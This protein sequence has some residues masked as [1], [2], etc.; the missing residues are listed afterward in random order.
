MNPVNSTTS[1]WKQRLW[2]LLAIIMT[3]LVMLIVGA[4]LLPRPGDVLEV[5]QWLHSHQILW[6]MLRFSLYAL[7]IF[8]LAPRWARK[9]EEDAESETPPVIGLQL[10]LTALAAVLE[11][12]IVQQGLAILMAGL[13]N[14]IDG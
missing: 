9:A 12:L 4:L 1:R 10:R 6:L 11:I 13:M 2:W 14:W 5:R 8:V 3:G 7:V